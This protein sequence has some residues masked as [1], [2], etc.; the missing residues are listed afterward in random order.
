MWEPVGT[1]SFLKYLA[2][3]QY[4]WLYYFL[5][6]ADKLVRRDFCFKN[7]AVADWAAYLPQASW[8]A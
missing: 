3:G 8:E 7:P 5:Q 1:L 4:A 6:V 2:R